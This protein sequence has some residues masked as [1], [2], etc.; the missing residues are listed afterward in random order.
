MNELKSHDVAISLDDFGTGYSSLSYLGR[1]P[2]DQLK[3]DQ[4]FVRRMQD[5][6]A[7]ASIIRSIIM[8]GQSLGL[9]II[10]E[11][12]ETMEQR[13]LLHAQG[14]TLYQGYWYGRPMSGEQFTALLEGRQRV[15]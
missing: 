13:D 6:A 12:V 15:A 10:A 11:G 4:S 8:L 1:F 9:S 7:T 2:I 14:C 5:D 3:I